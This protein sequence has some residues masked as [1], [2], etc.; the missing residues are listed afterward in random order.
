MLL[1]EIKVISTLQADDLKP[2]LNTIYTTS[3]FYTFLIVCV[4]YTMS[5]IDVT[6]VLSHAVR[7]C[8][9][10]TLLSI[11][12]E[13]RY[14]LLEFK[15][16]CLY[17]PCTLKRERVGGG[18]SNVKGG[19][20]RRPKI[21]VIRV[22]LQDQALYAHTSFRGAKMCKIGKKGR[23]FG[24]IDKFWKEHD[25][26]IKKY[27]C[28]N[29]HLGSF[30]IPEKYVIRVLFVSPWTS[31]IPPLVIRR[32]PRA[33]APLKTALILNV[34]AL[35]Q[36]MITRRIIII[37]SQESTMLSC[38]LFVSYSFCFSVNCQ[39]WR[40]GILIPCNKGRLASK[41]GN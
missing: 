38:I 13:C 5:L 17:S 1:L 3:K 26:Q 20:R 41:P 7:C 21:H 11:L 24:H 39:F 22:V 18:H 15:I 28:K 34:D 33:S 35:Y 4:F 12:V 37:I 14:R 27:A 8:F 40:T 23:V 10:T 6:L 2:F 30:F 9:S 32:P 31:L 25:R 16:E 19:I 36:I 29:A